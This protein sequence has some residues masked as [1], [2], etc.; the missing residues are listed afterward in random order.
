MGILMRTLKVRAT[1]SAEDTLDDLA[2]AFREGVEL[3]D[4][5]YRKQRF[6]VGS[7]A[8]HMFFLKS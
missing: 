4:R 3:K 8:V 6:V 7:E 2:E 1:M 5:K